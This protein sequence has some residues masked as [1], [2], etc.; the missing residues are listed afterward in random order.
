MTARTRIHDPAHLPKPVHAAAPIGKRRAFATLL[1]LASAPNAL[2]AACTGE[3][4]ALGP[5]WTLF[6]PGMPPLANPDFAHRAGFG[7]RIVSGDFNGDG[8]DDLAVAH[9]QFN[10]GAVAVLA[11]SAEG[12]VSAGVLTL[13]GA[14]LD[15]DSPPGFGARMVVADF[16]A[17]GYD[18]LAVSGS[19]GGLP[20]AGKVYVYYGG[21]AGLDPLTAQIWH[22][23]IDGIPGVAGNEDNFGSSLVAGNFDGDAYADLAIGAS[24]A[25]D[26]AATQMPVVHVLFGSS[27]GLVVQDN[28]ALEFPA[29][30]GV[31][32]KI[33]PRVAVD[34]DADGS[35]EL[36]V[37]FGVTGS[38]VAPFACLAHS[39]RESPTWSCFGEHS[40]DLT[41]ASYD[42]GSFAAADLDGDGVADVIA[43]EYR[44]NPGSHPHAGRARLWRGAG[45]LPGVIKP[46]AQFLTS[47]VGDTPGSSSRFATQLV[48]ADFDGD[49]IADVAIGEPGQSA[50]AGLNAAGLVHLYRGTPSSL[51]FMSSLSPVDIE[52]LAPLQPGLRF[53][54]ELATG[55]FDGD[56]CVDLAVGLQRIDVGTI[57][58]AGGVLVLGNRTIDIFKDGFEGSS[59]QLSGSTSSR[60]QSRPDPEM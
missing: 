52:L 56:G 44:Y 11:G 58:R 30:S 33:G 28:V 25:F 60:A 36:L 46:E 9:R 41:S 16:N 7:S 54:E 10:D 34:T 38:L 4:Q 15:T 29:A 20:V 1:L 23:D 57:D 35:D 21:P 18:D 24:R 42:P 32:N 47:P 55:D 14:L 26:A 53:G 22:R 12:L 6:T 17:D 43:G 45:S 37:T 49:G 2:A 39:L 31:A 48:A 51:T 3:L 40:P 27:A 5:L 8:R 19:G 13:Y 50:V 59:R